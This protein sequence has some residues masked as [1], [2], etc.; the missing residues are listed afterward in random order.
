LLFQLVLV[1]DFASG[2]AHL[3]FG[4]ENHIIDGHLTVTPVPETTTMVV[5]ALLVVAI[6]TRHLRLPRK[7][8]A[9][10]ELNLVLAKPGR[11]AR[12]ACFL[13]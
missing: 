2:N 10:K 11:S 6:G 5:G 8:N 9:G 13:V 4:W 7:Q 1:L 3:G 12:P